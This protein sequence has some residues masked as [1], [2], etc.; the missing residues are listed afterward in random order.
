MVAGWPEAGVQEV[1]REA[2][3]AVPAAVEEVSRGG[4]RQGGE[5]AAENRPSRQDQVVTCAA[6]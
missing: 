1:L 5:A 3:A 6:G 2:A 4:A